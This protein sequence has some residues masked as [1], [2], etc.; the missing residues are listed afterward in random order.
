MIMRGVGHKPEG[1][2]TERM[3]TVGRGIMVGKG[4]RAVVQSPLPQ[5]EAA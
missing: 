5:H 4:V 3:S 2:Q 1:A